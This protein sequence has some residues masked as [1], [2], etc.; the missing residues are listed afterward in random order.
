MTMYHIKLMNMHKRVPSAVTPPQYAGVHRSRLGPLLLLFADYNDA[1]V[2]S[3]RLSRNMVTDVVLHGNDITMKLAKNKEPKSG[4]K[5]QDTVA[6]VF[7]TDYEG[8]TDMCDK[9]NI[10][11]VIVKQVHIQ[12]YALDCVADTVVAAKPRLPDI[13]SSLEQRFKHCTNTKE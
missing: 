2:V 4:K 11:H 1:L 12:S 10:A 9:N 8:W 6:R 3:N 13:V 5:D 7:S